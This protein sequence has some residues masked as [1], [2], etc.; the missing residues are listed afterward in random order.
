MQGGTVRS[1]AR[2]RGRRASHAIYLLML[3]VLAMAYRP[4]M[5]ESLTRLNAS[6]LPAP[7]EPVRGLYTLDDT[8]LA[9]GDAG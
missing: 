5:A 4:A 2:G 9:S 1:W 3:V 8:L 7:P 6:T